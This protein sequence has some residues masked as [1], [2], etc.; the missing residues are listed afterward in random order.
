[1]KSCFKFFVDFIPVSFC[2]VVSLF[3][4][5]SYRLCVYFCE[6]RVMVSARGGTFCIYLASSELTS[7]FS[8]AEDI[9]WVCFIL[10]SYC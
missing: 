9:V 1:M 10:H 6:N 3:G 4:G 7:D 2:V 8:T 5:G